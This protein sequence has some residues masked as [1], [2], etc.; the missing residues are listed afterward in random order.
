MNKT[1]LKNIKNIHFIG[2]GGIG[3]GGIAE[4]LYKEGYNISGSDI[5]NNYIT[6][7]L[8]KLGINI[9]YHNKNNIS[10][11]IDIVV[12]SNSIKQ[13]NIEILESKRLNI[14]IINRG[15]ILKEIMRYRHGISISGSHGKTTTTSILIDIFIKNKIDVTFLN[16]GY[17]KNNENINLG[18]SN[19]FILESDES[20]LSFLYLNPISLI[21]TNIDNDHIRNYEN[22]FN[23]IL[24]SFLRFI[25][26]IPFYGKSILCIDD[27][28]IKNILNKVKSNF[29]TYGFDK[30]SDIQIEKI[31]K[32]DLNYSSFILKNNLCNYSIEVILNNIS[33]KFNIL[34]SVAAISL[35]LIENIDI[36]I[37]LKSLREF[38]GINRRFEIIKDKKIIEKINNKNLNNIDIISD[39]GHHP[40]EILSI[41]NNI[42]N[43]FLNRRLIMIFQ[44]HRYTRT[45]DLFSDFINVLLKVDILILVDIFS[46]EESNTFNISSYDLY[47]NI[48]KKNSN[49]VYYINNNE[50]LY[51][52]NKILLK[53]D[54][55]LIQGAGSINNIINSI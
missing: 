17:L 6:D 28:N 52:L 44:P 9:N 4:I 39:Y 43:I 21:V 33:G 30:K 46:A 5:S 3:I 31:N 37:I 55:F 11:T 7:K 2:I 25:N 50:I 14:P 15:E 36:D 27:I 47:I 24:K 23:N 13:D 10:N 35:S 26:N 49:I 32:L 34:N 22:N 18:K 16:G 8:I 51:I 48:K 42:R 29:I 12:P 1:I 45:Y 38:K 53:N 40:N 19:Y 41:I 20:D 54:V